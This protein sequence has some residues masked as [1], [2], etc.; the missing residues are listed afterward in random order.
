MIEKSQVFISRRH[1]ATLAKIQVYNLSVFLSCQCFFNFNK[2]VYPFYNYGIIVHSQLILNSTVFYDFAPN[3]NLFTGIYM[4]GK[5]LRQHM[6]PKSAPLSEKLKMFKEILLPRHPPVFHEWFL[7][8]FPDPTSWS[9]MDCDSSL[10][11]IYF[12]VFL[13]NLNEAKAERNIKKP[14]K[15]NK[16]KAVYTK[17]KNYL[18]VPTLHLQ[19]F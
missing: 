2:S 4:T 14:I 15:Q 18:K 9:V 19:K 8:T 1:L 16:T 11:L 5:E 17:S 12:K 3:L 13:Q 7:R 10:T 6:L